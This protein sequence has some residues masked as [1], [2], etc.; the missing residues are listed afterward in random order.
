MICSIR[1][2]PSAVRAFA[3]DFT[4][5]PEHNSK[6]KVTSRVHNTTNA[7]DAGHL[8]KSSP[9]H[10]TGG[11]HIRFGGET[12]RTTTTAATTMMMMILISATMMTWVIIATMMV[13][14]LFA[15]KFF[16]FHEKI[17]PANV[18]R[19]VPPPS[20]QRIMSRRHD[21]TNWRLQGRH[22]WSFA[23]SSPPIITGKWKFEETVVRE[24]NRIMLP[25]MPNYYSTKTSTHRKHGWEW[26]AGIPSRIWRVLVLSL[27][28]LASHDSIHSWSLRECVLQSPLLRQNKTKQRHPLFRRSNSSTTTST[29]KLRRS[30]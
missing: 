3:E 25:I 14:P 21:T 22:C 10:N 5:R 15:R 4:V 12:K 13:M 11:K 8:I 6:R 26:M 9:S 27:V 16:L 2:I 20:I 23:T 18:F 30:P 19:T 17:H 28:R 1:T 29:T 7:C 24:R